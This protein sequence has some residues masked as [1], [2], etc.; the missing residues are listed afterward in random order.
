MYKHIIYTTNST[1][2]KT[3]CTNNEANIDTME[4]ESIRDTAFEQKPFS[5]AH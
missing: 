1:Y 4:I 3:V 5:L 2:T